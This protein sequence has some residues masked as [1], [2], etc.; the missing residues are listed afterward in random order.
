MVSRNISLLSLAAFSVFLGSCASTMPSGAS[1]AKSHEDYVNP[2]EVG[3]YAHFEARKDYPVTY[4]TW[5]NLE[6]LPQTNPSNS[7]LQID[8]ERQRGLLMNGEKVVLDY[9]ISSG[10]DS[11]PTPDGKYKILEKVVDKRS[12]K[13]GRMYDSEG[14]VVNRDA[15]AFEDEVPEGGKFVGAPMKYW[16]RLTWDGIGHHIG[17]VE[18]YPAS[19]ACIRGPSKTMPIV[20]SKVALNTKVVVK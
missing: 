10:K 8:L 5:T 4:D 18:R 16:M 7:W 20:F 13:Y 14:Q 2:Y 19:H 6:L 3:T 1:L 15:N 12:N 11:H 17:N 9:P